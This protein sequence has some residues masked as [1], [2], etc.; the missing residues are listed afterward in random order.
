[1]SRSPLGSRATQQAAKICNAKR[2]VLREGRKR[3]LIAVIKAKEFQAT[4]A[5]VGNIQHRVGGHLILHAKVPLLVIGSPQ[6]RLDGIKFRSVGI[7]K[8]GRWESI[9]QRVRPIHIEGSNRAIE[10]HARA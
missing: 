9:G 2:C 5:R 8:R 4:R 10:R 7:R 6:I 1:M 3:C